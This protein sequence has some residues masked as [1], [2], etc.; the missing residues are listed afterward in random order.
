MDKRNNKNIPHQICYHPGKG[1][2]KT[3]S[4]YSNQRIPPQMKTQAEVDGPIKRRHEEKQHTPR[5]VIR[6]REL[7]QHDEKRQP[8]PGNDGKVRKVR[9]EQSNNIKR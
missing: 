8:Y 9:K 2:R 5:V 3:C 1:A 4:E 7:G 6:Q